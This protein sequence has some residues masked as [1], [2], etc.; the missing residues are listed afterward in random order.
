MRNA[1]A[2]QQP[3]SLHDMRKVV[4]Y[5][6]VYVR[7]LPESTMR[8][9]AIHELELCSA[10]MRVYDVQQL[11][12]SEVAD[13]AHK[14][15]AQQQHTIT[16][17]HTQLTDVRTSTI[18]AVDARIDTLQRDQNLLLTG[19]MESL[20]DVQHLSE[21]EVTRLRSELA[22]LRELTS[23]YARL[24]QTLH[25][26]LHVVSLQHDTIGELQQQVDGLRLVVASHTVK[27]SPLIHQ[28]ASITAKAPVLQDITAPPT[29]QRD[30]RTP[31]RTALFV[32]LTVACGAA[33][34]LQAAIATWIQ[35]TIP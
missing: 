9:R 5:L 1:W 12:D 10:Y 27:T 35:H 6:L 28:P 20:A 2:H 19:I 16:A 32:L 11:I 23:M 29:A 17:L 26:A 25:D 7:I 34:W 31:W 8:Q 18:P 14:V 24:Q 3:V 21:A 13:V 15:M 4:N 33:L 30:A 22:Q